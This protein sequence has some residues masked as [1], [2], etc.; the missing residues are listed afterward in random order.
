MVGTLDR[1]RTY[2]AWLVLRWQNGDVDAF[3]KLVARFERPLFYYLMRLV[4]DEPSAWDVL[5]EVWLEVFRKLK[6]LKEPA[7]FRVW[8]Y[9]VAHDRAVTRV[10]REVR[11]E[12]TDE[13]DVRPGEEFEVFEDAEQVHACLNRLRP[14]H[15]EVLTLYFLEGMGYEEIAEVVGAGVGTVKSRLHY[16]KKEVR[17]LIEESGGHA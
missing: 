14:A 10:R 6:K 2:E 12:E 4:Q 5:Q 3:E 8:L 13:V 9:R 15:R 16:A 17:R 11:R 7:A 1:E